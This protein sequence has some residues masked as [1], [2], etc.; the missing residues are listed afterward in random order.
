[1]KAL[2]VRLEDELWLK[3]K[4]KMLLDGE[5]FQGLFD[6][7]VQNY[8]KEDFK[9]KLKELENK[10]GSTEFEGKKYILTSAAEITGNTLDKYSD[11]EDYFEMSCPALD[12]DGNNYTV[13]WEF[14]NDGRELD[15][16][17]YDKAF[18]VKEA[19]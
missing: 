18:I 16:Y 19:E 12:L 1:M 9:V 3:A 4:Q 11:G 6:K 5:N 14:E 2:S 7:A 10:W 17:D 13:Y 15:E 8:I